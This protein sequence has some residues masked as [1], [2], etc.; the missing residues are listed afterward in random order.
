MIVHLRIPVRSDV[1]PE[2]D[3]YSFMQLPAVHL[4]VHTQFLP[5]PG[6]VI[7]G[8]TSWHVVRTVVHLADGSSAVDLTPEV[9]T[10]P[11]T[12]DEGE[13]FEFY[14]ASMIDDFGVVE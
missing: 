7:H 3:D 11:Y 2:P 4:V 9:V 10:S 8:A 13:T 5:R 12:L 14:Q 6:D 1:P